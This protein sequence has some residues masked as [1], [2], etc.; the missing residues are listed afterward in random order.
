MTMR[1]VVT[2]ADGFIG[3]NLVLRLQELGHG[4]DLVRITRETAP[5]DLAKLITG[6][7]FIF[8]LAGINRPKHESEF[9]SGNLEFTRT[10]CD[11]V[12]KQARP[13]P[14][15]YTSSTQAD[16]DN[17]YGN[18]K[19]Q[20][21]DVLRSYGHEAGA[22]VHIFRLPNV[23]GKWARPNYNSAVATFCY[24]IARD[25]PI[26]INDPNAPLSMVYIDDVISAFVGLLEDNS[27]FERTPEVAPVYKTTV[28]EV[29]DYIRSFEAG[30]HS[31]ITQRVGTGLLRALHAT[32][33][34]YLDPS[35]FSY[36]VTVHSDNRG[37]FVEMLKT[38][39]SGQLSYFT[40]HP[41]ITRGEHYH[42]TKTEKFLVIRGTARF[43]F[44]HVDTG[45]TFEIETKG[46][47]AT[48]VETVPGWAHNVTNVGDD[49][50]VCMLWANEIF[51]RANPDTIACK[52]KP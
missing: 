11:A 2:G 40:A 45:E 25:L 35:R 32:Y 18:S 31:L 34:S 8:H 38:E 48:I 21:E 14:I 39:D 43:G 28:G 12:S 41:G 7:N 51:D 20:A 15:A 24:N 30:R 5:G 9:A 16:R 29:A 3:R 44:R 19:R 46:G 27:G 26:T 50:L 22:K 4:N 10:L 42:H 33:L 6:A 1:I 13:I 17:P 52:V 37:E 49:E 36:V 47:D 23:F